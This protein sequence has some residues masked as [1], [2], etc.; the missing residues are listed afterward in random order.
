M[1]LTIGEH[2]ENIEF[3]QKFELMPDENVQV[4]ENISV[5]KEEGDHSLNLELYSFGE[6]IVTHEAEVT[7]G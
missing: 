7:I 2:S 1:D 4:E 3:E 5:M 6:E